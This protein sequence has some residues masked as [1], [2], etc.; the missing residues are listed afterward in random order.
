MQEQRYPSSDEY[1]DIDRGG[2]SITDYDAM[3]DLPSM[4]IGSK[5][6]KNDM[7]RCELNV[8]SIIITLPRCDVV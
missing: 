2:V 6:T 3:N 8:Q 1:D 5:Q 7:F 4:R